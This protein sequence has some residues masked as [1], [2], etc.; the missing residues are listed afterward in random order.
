MATH[1]SILSRKLHGQRRLTG[2]SPWDSKEA[3]TTEHI[4]GGK[5]YNRSLFFTATC[6]SIISHKKSY[7][8]RCPIK[9]SIIIKLKV[10]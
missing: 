8:Q 9:V 2:Y 4:H 7:I 10:T 5:V 6:K 1:T 3:D